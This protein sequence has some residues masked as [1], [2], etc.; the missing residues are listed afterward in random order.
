MQPDGTV[1]SRLTPLPRGR[2]LRAQNFEIVTINAPQPG[3]WR[4]V[5]PKPER[6]QVIGEIGIEV[7]GLDS[8]VVP[9]EDSSVFIRLYDRGELIR[10]RAFLD[11]LDIR[12]WAVVDGERMP[13]PLDAIDDG[14]EAFF[15]NLRDGAHQFELDVIAPTFTRVVTRPFVVSNP[16]RVEIREDHRAHRGARAQA[17]A[18]SHPAT[19]YAYARRHLAYPAG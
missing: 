6:V 7:E 16:L 19:W 2:W 1:L 12:A 10:D 17:A 3:W 18:D 11:L 8:P 13:L 4:I 9:S 14:Y 15:V 5:G